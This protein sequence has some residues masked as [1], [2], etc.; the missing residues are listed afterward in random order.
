[1]EPVVSTRKWDTQQTCLHAAAQYKLH[2]FNKEP[3]EIVREE[4]LQSTS[5]VP[6][7]WTDIKPGLRG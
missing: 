3:Y 5:G 7:S 6:G 2:S 1:M 4:K